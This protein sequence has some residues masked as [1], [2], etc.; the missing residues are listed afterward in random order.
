ML[1][2][3][4][5]FFAI[6]PLPQP[7]GGVM[8]QGSIIPALE[9]YAYCKP[10][11]QDFIMADSN[12]L[13]LNKGDNFI[14]AMDV[15]AS[16]QQTDC[17]NNTQRIEYLKEGVSTFCREAG[18]W[19]DDGLDIITFGSKIN[20]LKGIT[21]DKAVEVI[22][23]LNATEGST[24]T[25]GAIN[26]AYKLHKDAAKAQT[27]LFI[28]TDGLPNDQKA[29]EKAI[30]DITNDIKDEHE[31]AISFLKVG[32]EPSVDAW[33]TKLDDD[34]TKAGAKFDIV[35]VKNLDEVDFDAAFAGALHD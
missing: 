10:I 4:Q 1:F 5:L 17:P 22:G 7:F 13:E 19:D 9:T 23:K 14:F 2:D 33:L 30:I 32:K 8:H 24:D 28:A 15:S 11:R 29:V 20:V 26:A 3:K 12:Q 18:K 34:L 21:P 25:A 6:H 27:V 31:F 35:D 16:M